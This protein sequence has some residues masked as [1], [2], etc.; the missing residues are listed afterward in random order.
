[1][2]SQPAKITAGRCQRAIN[3]VAGGEEGLRRER[4]QEGVGWHAMRW[5]GI[6]LNELKAAS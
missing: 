4:K 5:K 3:I 1:M 2:F 6:L